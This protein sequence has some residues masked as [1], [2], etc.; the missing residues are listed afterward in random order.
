MNVKWKI[1]NR[2]TGLVGIAAA[3][4]LAA[5]AGSAVHGK[6]QRE[7]ESLAQS[8]EESIRAESEAALRESIANQVPELSDSQ[9]Q[10]LDGIESAVRGKNLETAARMMAEHGER[11]WV[12]FYDLLDGQLYLYH[13]GILQKKLEG[14]GLLIRRPT[15]VYV[16]NLLDGKPEG[17]GTALQ[18]V[19]LEYPRY[20][21]SSGTW[22]DGKMNGEGGIGYRYYDGAGDEN[23]AAWR[24]G[25]FVD[26]RMDGKLTYSTTN[27]AGETSTWSMTAEAGKLVIDDRWIFDEEK[28]IYQLMSNEENGN[29]Y[30][31]GKEVVEET[32]FQ[33]LIP[34]E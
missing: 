32:R 33:N 21:Y 9:I 11:L 20:D 5:A 31:V 12:L 6:N 34:W 30:V 16:G 1:T 28:G 29:A 7:A 14:Q 18:V 2:R 27:G 10:L 8:A 4:L 25:T 13:D 26:D 17:E 3:V 19:E 23:Q 24:E 15:S 22:K